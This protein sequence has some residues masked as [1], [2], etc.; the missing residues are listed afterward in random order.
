MRFLLVTTVVFIALGCDADD[1]AASETTA[2]RCTRV[3]DHLVKLHLDATVSQ[4]A[5]AMRRTPQVEA[6]IREQHRTALVASLGDFAERCAQT[7]TVQ[8]V[9]CVI[10]AVDAEAASACTR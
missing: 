7:M 2:Q 3:R 4:V 5:P 1:E 9:D 6:S 10:D 8:Q